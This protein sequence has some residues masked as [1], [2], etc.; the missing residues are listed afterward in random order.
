MSRLHFGKWFKRHRELILYGEKNTFWFGL[1]QILLLASPFTRC[2]WHSANYPPSLSPRFLIH[3]IW[4]IIPHR[5]CLGSSSWEAEPERRIHVQ[6]LLRTLSQWRLVRTQWRKKG[7]K[8]S[9]AKATGISFILILR[10]DSRVQVTPHRYPD[11]KQECWGLVLLGA[12]PMWLG[13]WW[14]HWLEY[15]CQDGE[16]WSGK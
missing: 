3:K 4:I 8:W 11:P 12:I 15:T 7:S 9:K 10:G 13:G 6:D 16:F 14:S 1:A 2:T 5:I